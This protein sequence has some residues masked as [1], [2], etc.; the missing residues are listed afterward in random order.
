MG[1]SP[2]MTAP[3]ESAA[4]ADCAGARGELPGRP[5]R[6]A[7]PVSARPSGTPTSSPAASMRRGTTRPPTST[8]GSPAST[9][10]EVEVHSRHG[11]TAY[12]RPFLDLIEANRLDQTVRRYPTYDDLLGYCR[13]R[14]TRSGGSCSRSSA[15]TTPRPARLSDLVC[16]ALQ[17]LEHCQDVAEDR[18]AAPDLPAGRGPARFGVAE[19]D[20]DAS[21]TPRRPAAGRLRG[22]RAPASARRRRAHRRAAAR[23]GAARRRRLRRRRPR[24]G[25]RAATRPTTTCSAGAA[26]TAHDSPCSASRAGRCWRGAR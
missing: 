9:S 1:S 19:A 23:L 10:L 13:S 14:P 7:R 25:R 4:G 8:S 2:G 16:T 24:H 5:A 11:G 3:A 21:V 22:G 12:E 6:A 20:L 26:T 15:S 18:R 17:I